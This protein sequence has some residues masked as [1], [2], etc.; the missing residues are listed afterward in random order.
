MQP[1]TWI[2]LGALF[3]A[4]GVGA[5][6]F[7][8]HVM[9]SRKLESAFY[10]M[11]TDNTTPEE[12]VTYKRAMDHFE[13]AVRYQMYHALAMVGAGILGLYSQRARRAAWLAGFAY[14]VGIIFFSGSL[15]GLV[16]MPQMKWLGMIA[17]IGGLSMIVGW[18]L[19]AIAGMFATGA[20]A[21]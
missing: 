17:P 2:I 11:P 8:A 3:G 21:E 18:V 1:R 10:G 4:L 15:Y 14:L 16:F 7:G 13:T 6:A 20:T 5:G 12:V 19:L 9:T